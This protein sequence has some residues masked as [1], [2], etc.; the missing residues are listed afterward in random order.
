ME[1]IPRGEKLTDRGG[2]TISRCPSWLLGQFGNRDHLL[3]SQVD[4]AS[5]GNEVGVLLQSL[6]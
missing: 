5:Y 2:G 3:L 6:P 4:S 1:G